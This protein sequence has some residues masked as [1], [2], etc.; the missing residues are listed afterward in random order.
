[1]ISIITD[2]RNAYEAHDHDEFHRHLKRLEEMLR[3]SGPIER[4]PCQFCDAPHGQPHRYNCRSYG[5]VVGTP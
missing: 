3:Y 4:R 1:M 2:L 5:Q